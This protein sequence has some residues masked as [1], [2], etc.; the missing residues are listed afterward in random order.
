MILLTVK[1]FD[2]RKNPPKDGEFERAWYRLTNEDTNQ[3]V[4]YKNIK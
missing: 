4:D 3:T 1:T 2:L